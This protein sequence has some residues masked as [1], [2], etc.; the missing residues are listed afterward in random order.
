M[1]S[2]QKRVIGKR[3]TLI[4]SI[5][6]LLGAASWLVFG[7]N[8]I[9]QSG[10]IHNVTI[11]IPAQISA[12]AL[13]VGRDQKFFE[14]HGLNLTIQP[15]LL[16]KQALQST[17]QGKADLAILA[18]TP[19]M[20]AVINGEKIATVATIFGSRR[21]MA[22]VARKDRGI[23][24]AE[25]LSGKTI[26]TIFGTNAQFFVDTLLTAHSITKSSVKIVYLKPETLVEA[27]K[28]GEVDAVTVWHPDLAEL[29]QALA[30][31]VVTIYDEDI[32]VYRFILVGK[33]DYLDKHAA[34][35]RQT[36]AA[37]EEA[38]RFIREQ[39]ARAKITISKALS[40]DSVLLSKTFDPNDFYLTLDQTLLLALSDETRWAMKQGIVPAGPVPNY[41]NYIRQEPLESVL[42]SA[43][44]IIK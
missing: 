13:Y 16:G 23:D 4:F 40:M 24:K 9:H 41:L 39:P 2:P 42:P 32:F 11:A 22:V 30:N 26:G 28:N 33:Q 6:C 10:P 15:F 38:T 27:L 35:V 20:L 3:F 19:F 44:K 29:E 34:E 37:I 7:N 12:G 1:L 21:S 36:L 31:R 17:L 25:D 43:I 8:E 14:K 5:I 18:E